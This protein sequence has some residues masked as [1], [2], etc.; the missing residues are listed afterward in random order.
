MDILEVV[1]AG[2]PIDDLDV[3]DGA[4]LITSLISGRRPARRDAAPVQNPPLSLYGAYR[5]GILDHP[6]R[7]GNPYR[8]GSR[9]WAIWEEGR[10]EAETQRA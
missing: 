7:R 1:S 9:L 5:Q 4:S 6:E 3:I 8:A 2:Q 10:I